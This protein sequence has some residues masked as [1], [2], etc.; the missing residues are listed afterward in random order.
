MRALLWTNDPDDGTD[1]YEGGDYI[2][3]MQE[4]NGNLCI[5]VTGMFSDASCEIADTAQLD[6]LIGALV[7]ARKARS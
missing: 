5:V 2:S 4:D 1:D 7:K 6:A 3:L